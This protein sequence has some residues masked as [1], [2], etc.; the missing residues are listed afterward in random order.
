MLGDG[1]FNTCIYID[2]TVYYMLQ[3]ASTH[4]I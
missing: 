1:L 2:N 4:Y 3:F